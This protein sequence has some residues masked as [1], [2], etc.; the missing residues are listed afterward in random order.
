MLGAY[1]IAPLS[2]TAGLRLPAAARA[3]A[4]A[5]SG[6]PAVPA[7]PPGSAGGSKGLGADLDPLLRHQLDV[8]TAILA[9]YSHFFA[10]RFIEQS[11]RGRDIDFGYLIFQ[12]TF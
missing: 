8:H 3:D 7:S 9:G 6:G 1:R 2:A 12:Y 11:G 4:G 5:E 10:G